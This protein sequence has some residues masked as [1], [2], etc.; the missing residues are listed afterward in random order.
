MTTYDNL[1]QRIISY[2]KLWQLMITYRDLWYRMFSYHMLTKKHLKN[3]TK[4]DTQPHPQTHTAHP[5]TTTSTHTPNNHKQTQWPTHGPTQTP[6]DTHRHPQTPHT[7]KFAKQAMAQGPCTLDHRE[8][9]VCTWSW[10]DE[11]RMMFGW[12]TKSG[13]EWAG[14]CAGN[15]IFS[16]VSFSPSLALF[17]SL[18]LFVSWS[19]VIWIVSCLIFSCDISWKDVEDWWVFSLVSVLTKLRCIGWHTSQN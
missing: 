3:M 2:H 13:M 4:A 10:L 12:V 1:W 18:C 14:T 8:N 15:W 17:L 16:F 6:T 11:W 9:A 5:Q 19:Q 7:E